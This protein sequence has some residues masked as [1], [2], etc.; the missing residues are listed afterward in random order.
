MNHSNPASFPTMTSAHAA[1]GDALE[2][3]ALAAAN[4]LAEATA[5]LRAAK[6]PLK[7][8]RIAESFTHATYRD[9]EAALR[10]QPGVEMTRHRGKTYY[11]LRADR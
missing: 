3:H 2:R 11:Y 5:V 10:R 1:S 4:Q 6:K 9:T 8:N 7:F